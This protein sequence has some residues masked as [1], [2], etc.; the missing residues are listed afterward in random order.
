MIWFRGQC[1]P[2]LSGRSRKDI[3]G[4]EDWV[5]QGTLQRV[6]AILFAA[7]FFCV[8]IALPFAAILARAE[9]SQSTG[10]DW[11]QVFGLGLAALALLV[12]FAAMLLSFRLLRGI[13]R[14]F[15]K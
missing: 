5:A 8:A 7:V 9:I 15:Y 10:G 3:F 13:V 12:A 2:I 1:V 14:S 11:G 6:G 4:S